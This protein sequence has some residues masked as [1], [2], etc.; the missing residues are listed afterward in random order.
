MKKH[1]SNKSKNE[2]GFTIIEVLIVLAIAALILVVVLVAIPQLQR[3]QRNSARQSDASRVV[4]SV[5]SWSANNNGQAFPDGSAAALT[6]VENDLGDLTQYDLA[7]LT[8]VPAPS[9]GLDTFVITDINQMRIV[10]GAA[11]NSD[12][13]GEVTTSGISS[14]AV[15]V[16]YASETANDPEPQ[17]ISS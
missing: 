2:Q 13:Q 12:E 1:L 9:S 3:N 15:A 6:S 16:Q 17:C 4:T 14:R 10:P 5:Q 11:C 8:A 7:N